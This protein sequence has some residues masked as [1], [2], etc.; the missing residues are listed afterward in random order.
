MNFQRVIARVPRRHSHGTP[1]SIG[2]LVLLVA[3]L[4]FAGC[5]VS[6]SST[7]AGDWLWQTADST[8]ALYLHIGDQTGQAHYVPY[9]TAGNRAD[10]A[11]DTLVVAD[12]KV[13]FTLQGF[14]ACS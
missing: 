5:G 8:Q 3:T 12:Q 7:P 2:L 11:S 6:S 4:V 9:D 1:M 10:P 13:Q 14:Q